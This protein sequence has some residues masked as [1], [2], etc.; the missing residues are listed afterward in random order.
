MTRPQTCR[1]S[2]ISH[3]AR[4]ASYTDPAVFD[5]E[6]RADLRA[7]VVLRRA[8][9]RPRRARAPSG[10][11]QVGRESVLHRP[12]PPAARCAAFFNVCRHRGARLCTEESGEVKRAFQCPY[13]AWT[14]D[15]DGKLIAAPNLT[16]MPDIDRVEYG[17]RAGRTCASGSATSGSAWP[18]SRRRSRTTVMRRGRRP[19]RRRRVDRRTTTSATWRSAGG[20]ATTSRPTGSSIV[21]NF[22]ECYHCATIHPELIE[23]LPEFADGLRRPV[24][25]RPRRAVRRRTIEGF[26]VDGSRRPGRSSPA[27][28]AGAGPPLLRDHDQAAGLHQPGA[29]PRDLAPD[30]PAG[31]RPHDRRVRLALP[32]RGGR[33]GRRPRR[34]RSSCS[35]GST[36]RTSRPA[37]GASRRCARGSTRDGGVLVPS[38]H[39]IG[40]VPRLGARPPADA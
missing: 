20:S 22:M 24:L 31:G 9:R 18:T 29:R 15:L 35:T 5:A 33:R 3:P 8:R 11:S 34:R 40:D 10:P 38:E 39:H 30:V 36:S 13:H 28:A 26:T 23:V 16:K 1:E 14:Y 6:Q 32:A 25:R 21:E 27:S 4:R 37:S 12:Q 2:L 19:A 7:D 17:L